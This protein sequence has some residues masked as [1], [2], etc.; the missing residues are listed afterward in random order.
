ML[1]VVDL[2]KDEATVDELGIGT[3]RDALSDQLFPGTSVLHTRL[4]YVLFIPWLLQRATAHSRTPPEMAA[5]FRRLEYRLIDSLLAGGESAGVFGN[6]ARGDLKRT[7]S[8]AYWSALASWGIADVPSADAYFRRTRDLEAL[9]RRSVGNDDPESRAWM[10]QTGLD[11]SLPAPPSTL[12]KSDTFAL[13]PDEEEYLSQ[14]IEGSARRSM[15]AWLIQHPPGNLDDADPW[16]LDNLGQAPAHLQRLVDHARR[17]SITIHGAMIVYNLLLAE[18]TGNDELIARYEGAAV[19]WHTEL[20]TSH[21]LDDWDRTDWWHTVTRQ[22]PRL[23]PATRIFVDSWITVLHASDGI[24][25][26]PKARDLVASRERQIKGGR[27]RLA[28]PAAL[29]QWR[30]SSG[31]GKLSFRWQIARSHLRDLYAARAA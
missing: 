28:N 24:A 16:Q 1:E 11:A 30:G 10:P 5:E 17:F 2:F 3:I 8:I 18:K 22:N 29:D 19:E 25:R 27:A 4:R 12:L 9:R 15:L 23:R 21:A 7:P 6:R 20:A 31:M 13:T 26:D 14:R